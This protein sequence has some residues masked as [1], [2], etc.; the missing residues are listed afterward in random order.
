[1]IARASREDNLQS[2]FSTVVMASSAFWWLGAVEVDAERQSVPFEFEA[3]LC[4]ANPKFIQTHM[5]QYGID[6][7]DDGVLNGCF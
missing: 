1:M 7:G 6:I 2:L 4:R 5:K 3:F